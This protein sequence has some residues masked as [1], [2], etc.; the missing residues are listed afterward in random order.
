M[1][2]LGWY[3]V[4][5]PRTKKTKVKLSE[6]EKL[7][8]KIEK[9]V[10]AAMKK[11]PIFNDEDNNAHYRRLI[12]VHIVADPD[13]SARDVAADIA[14]VWKTQW[15]DKNEPSQI[16]WHDEASD[17]VCFPAYFGRYKIDPKSFKCFQ[18]EGPTTESVFFE[19]EQRRNVLYVWDHDGV[20]K[21]FTVSMK[22]GKAH[23]H[24]EPGKNGM[25]VRL[26]VDKNTMRMD[27]LSPQKRTHCTLLIGTKQ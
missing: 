18:I 24:I 14:K 22:G 6:D 20:V 12:L 27:V 23:G 5:K 19:V 1:K 8:M 25:S 21:T 7:Q 26:V 13:R 17:N 9:E 3:Q 4:K 11:Y 16:C 15:I 10:A 2:K